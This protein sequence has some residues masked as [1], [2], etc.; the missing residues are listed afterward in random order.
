VRL[1]FK[2]TDDWFNKGWIS[3]MIRA[4][5]SDHTSKKG[6]CKSEFYVAFDNGVYIFVSNLNVTT[7]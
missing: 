6:L 4:A 7:F 3:T 1:S 5:K 2:Q